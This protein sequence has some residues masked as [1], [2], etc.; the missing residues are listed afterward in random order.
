MLSFFHIVGMGV[1]KTLVLM[2]ISILYIVLPIIGLIKNKKK[3]CLDSEG[4]LQTSDNKHNGL[5]VGLGLGLSVLTVGLLFRLMHWP[6][7]SVNTTVGM[8]ITLIMSVVIFLVSKENTKVKKVAVMAAL[9]SLLFG[10]NYLYHFKELYL[11]RE[12]PQYIEAYNKYYQEPTEEN[13]RLKNIEGSKVFNCDRNP[14]RYQHLKELEKKAQEMA[15]ND[16]H[17][18]YIYMDLEYGSIPYVYGHF[19]NV[20]EMTDYKIQLQEY[21]RYEFSEGDVLYIATENEKVGDMLIG[22]GVSKDRFVIV[23]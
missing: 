21:V 7:G 11:F 9:C 14:G 15:A 22:M 17:G 6:G 16:E 8:F 3:A 4:N 10:T 23:K 18:K 1:V 19:I 20:I 5:L 13:N 2:T 12:F